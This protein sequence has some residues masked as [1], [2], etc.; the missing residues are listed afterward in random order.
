MIRLY[1]VLDADGVKI[2]TITADEEL[3]KTDWYP[4]FGA[5]L[6]DE[7]ENP[8]DPPPE[9]P[10]GKPDTWTVIAQLAEPMTNGDK[11]DFKTLE[12]T[13]AELIQADPILID[14]MPVEEIKP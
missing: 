11:I 2:S 6:V 3:L 4:G 13:K 8:P 14:P 12:V 7:G 5:A 1:G 9:K 10:P